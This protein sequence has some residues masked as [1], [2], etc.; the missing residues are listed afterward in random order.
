MSATLAPDRARLEALIGK[1]KNA[2]EEYTTVDA[3][4]YRRP[5]WRDEVLNREARRIFVPPPDPLAEELKEEN[6]K[7]TGEDGQVKVDDQFLALLNEKYSS[8]D[9]NAELLKQTRGGYAAIRAAMDWEKLC[10][11][12]GRLDDDQNQIYWLYHIHDYDGHRNTEQSGAWMFA[13]VGPPIAQAS[14]IDVLG[15]RFDM[16]ASEAAS[17]VLSGSGRGNSPPSSWLIHLSDREELPRPSGWTKPSGFLR[18]QR[19]VLDFSTLFNGTTPMWKTASQP[20]K[21]GGRV[22]SPWWAARLRNV[23]WLSALACEAALESAGQ[24][25]RSTT[26]GPTKPML[27]FMASA[28]LTAALGL[29]CDMNNAVDLAL[30]RYAEQHADCREDVPNPRKGEPR[31]MYRVDDVWAFLVGRLPA[32]LARR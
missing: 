16:L 22:V 32:W 12:Q 30:R 21:D 2:A 28:D 18:D 25:G 1:L 23:F 14:A 15:R 13:L 7:R 24:S 9:F 8:V 4:V 19:Q 31:V 6:F 20:S 3:V 5:D 17:I 26:T 27:R 10:P 11:R 29:P